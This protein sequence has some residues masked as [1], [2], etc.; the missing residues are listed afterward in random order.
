LSQ[1]DPWNDQ[2]IP[3]IIAD[4]DFDDD[5]DGIELTTL[6]D[7]FGRDDCSEFDPCECDLDGDGDVDD[8]NLFL[9][10]EDFGRINL[11]E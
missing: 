1:S 11:S 9:F 7:E 5:T 8:V 4:F 6:I 3:P 10:S 2:D